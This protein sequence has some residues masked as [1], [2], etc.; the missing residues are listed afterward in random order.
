M[1]EVLALLQ[2]D[3]VGSTELSGRLGADSVR[4]WSGRFGRSGTVIVLASA[5]G[6]HDRQGTGHTGHGERVA[7]RA[8]QIGRA[9]GLDD[10]TRMTIRLG[11][12]L[13]DV[14]N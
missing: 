3:V 6:S 12:L 14:G 11:S 1:S 2:T 13:R 10:S 8:V 9:L 4:D 5:I 7:A